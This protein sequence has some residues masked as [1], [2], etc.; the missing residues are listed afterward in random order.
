MMAMTETD[1]VAAP[2]KRLS[3]ARFRRRDEE[4]QVREQERDLDAA[5]REVLENLHRPSR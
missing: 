3:R 1:P 5:Y 2:T 4:P